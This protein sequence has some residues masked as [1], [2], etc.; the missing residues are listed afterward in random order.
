MRDDVWIP[1]LGR[2]GWTLISIDRNQLRKPE[3]RA[4]LRAGGAIAFYMAKTFDHLPF[5]EQ[6]WRLV[7]FW[8]AI[9]DAAE[10]TRQGQCYL[11]RTN[12]GIEVLPP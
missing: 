10:R 6:A 3:E 2:N 4:A 5:M 8:P 11:V 1:Q 12:G 9:T 7:K